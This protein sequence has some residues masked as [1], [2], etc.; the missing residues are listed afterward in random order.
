MP[1]FDRWAARLPRTIPGYRFRRDAGQISNHYW[2]GRLAEG[3]VRYQLKQHPADSEPLKALH[4]PDT[5][6]HRLG[7][8]ISDL[9]QRASVH[10]RWLNLTIVLLLSSALERFVADIAVTAINSDPVLQNGSPKKVDGL[11]L[12]KYGIPV[13]ERNVVSLVKGD[14]P[15]RTAA[16]EKLFGC[17]APVDEGT[18]ATLER[19]RR[20]RNTIAH[21]FG[22]DRSENSPLSSEASILIEGRGKKQNTSGGVSGNHQGAPDEIRVSDSAVIKYFDHVQRYVDAVDAILLAKFIGDYEPAIIYA[23]WKLDPDGFEALMGVEI[24]GAKR[25]HSDRFQNFLGE[26]FDYPFGT[27]YC[28]SLE[29]YFQKL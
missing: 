9:G 17:P 12:T 7:H 20:T 21:S 29:T 4:L 23:Q 19:L 18:L 26:I 13:P 24:I 10:K 27:E 2:V 8:S 11:L 1:E 25:S 3:A 14:W 15:A 28:R 6:E 16:F 5:F 22:I